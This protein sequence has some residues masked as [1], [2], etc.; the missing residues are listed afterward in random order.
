MCAIR[1]K[2]GFARITLV[3]SVGY[4]FVAALNAFAAD[5]PSAVAPA[6][7]WTVHFLD[8]YWERLYAVQFD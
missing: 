6:P 4:P 2:F 3:A 7:A 1:N 5:P 8:G